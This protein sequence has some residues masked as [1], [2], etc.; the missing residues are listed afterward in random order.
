MSTPASTPPPE[1]TVIIP[2][3][4]SVKHLAAAIE[5][6]LAQTF[7]SYELIIVDDGST[8]GSLA[9][10][11]S[12]AGLQ[13]GVISVLQHPDRGNHGVAAARNLA[14]ARARGRYLAFLDSDD[15]WHPNKL[16]VQTAY[17]HQRPELG[18]TFTLARIVR[19]DEGQ[20]FIPGVDVLGG[21]P[22]E[23]R[24]TAFVMIATNALNYIFSS[25][26]VRRDC[27]RAAGGFPE[28]LPFQSEDRILVAKVSADHGVGRVPEVLCEYLAHG[29]SYSA[30]VVRRGTAAVIFFDLQVRLVRWLL[31]ENGKPDWARH[32]TLQVLPDTLFSALRSRRFTRLLPNVLHLARLLPAQ[33]PAFFW[34]VFHPARLRAGRRS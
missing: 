13:P 22:P 34:R 6:V 10:A 12:Y 25:V 29:S 16:Q 7:R 8:D 9:I 33:M 2:V 27:L 18:L 20:Q 15:R 5:S 17:M 32:L 1:V 26:M 24:L 19:D 14:A 3:Y 11:Q 31:R 23:D 4:N 28:G 21:L 30:D